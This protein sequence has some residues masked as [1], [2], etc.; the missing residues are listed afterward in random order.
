MHFF[1]TRKELQTVIAHECAHHH[2]GAML[3]NR[4]HYRTTILFQGFLD[5]FQHVESS[6]LTKQRQETGGWAIIYMT[7][8]FVYRVNIIFIYIFSLYLELMAFLVRDS[9]YE[10]YCDYVAMNL[11]GGNILA[12]SLEKLLDLNIAHNEILERKNEGELLDYLGKFDRFFHELQETNPPIRTKCA[13]IKTGTH[14]SLK[15][16]I[17]RALNEAIPVEDLSFPVLTDSEFEEIFRLLIFK[18]KGA[19]FSN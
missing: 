9:D 17:E 13:S 4:V 7:S 12:S 14:P 1:I 19:V 10:F 15:A 18:I 11:Y 2:H 5:A 16:R 8:D 6:I 3:P